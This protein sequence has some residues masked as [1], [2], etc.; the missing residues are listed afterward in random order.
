MCLNF[1]I[2]EILY[3]NNILLSDISDMVNNFNSYDYGDIYF[4][5]GYEQI[6]YL[7]NNK[8]KNNFFKSIQGVSV[9]LNKGD[10]TFFSYINKINKKNIFN[11]IKNLNL[12]VKN[13]ILFNNKK[14]FVIKNKL[15]NKYNYNFNFKLN[16]KKIEVLYDLYNYI[17]NKDKRINFIS[18]SLLSKCDLILICNSDYNINY[19]IRPLVNLSIKVQMEN[20]FNREIGIS[21]GGGNYDFNFL[22][23]KKIN[24]IS[25]IYH[26]ANES[27][28]I[29][30]NNLNALKTPL[31]S[32]PIV[33][34]SGSPGILL[35]EAI[36]HGLESDF[37]RRRTSLFYDKLNKK[38]ASSN[39]TIID[40]NSIKEKIGSSSIDDEG[41][42]CQKRVL[43]K[44]GFLLSYLLDRL[45]ARLMNL[46]SNGCGRRESYSCL[47]IPRMSNTYLLSGNYKVSDIINSVDYGIY[48]SN[49]SGG[50]VDISSG[51]FVFTILE[52]YLIKNGN[53]LHPIKKSSLIGS[54]LNVMNNISM[55]GD[56]LLFD[57][58]LGVCGKD[59]QSVYVSVGQPTLK[60][61]S[62][63]V[64]GLN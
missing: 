33:L 55:V 44:N 54:S 9:R 21:G 45:N 13:N 36:G 12:L 28:R 42:V 15:I 23:K 20:K 3:K 49:L 5:D 53:I 51:N 19:D 64:G 4:Q 52:G 63:T 38:V 62:M 47:P 56:D 61:N 27:V 29:A 35:H 14:L 31:G 32:M 46:E 58:G 41:I 60:I 57:Y 34:S 26:W 25:L 6:L 10:K 7:E 37:N 43:I 11:I 59:N 40:D 30:L 39:C 8:L 2:E 18:L 16:K 48:I 17:K 50:Q 1:I 22:L 24:N